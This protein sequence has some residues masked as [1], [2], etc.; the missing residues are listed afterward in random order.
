MALY[1]WF[2]KTGVQP[3]GDGTV[4]VLEKQPGSYLTDAG[5]EFNF[6][7]CSSVTWIR[8][9]DCAW[10]G[11][12]VKPDRVMTVAGPGQFPWGVGCA[13]GEICAA[14]GHMPCDDGFEQAWSCGS[15]PASQVDPSW[16]NTGTTTPNASDPVIQQLLE[17]QMPD[18]PE[19]VAKELG[20]LGTPAEGGPTIITG[21]TTQPGGTS[22]KTVHPDGSSS[23][24]TTNYNITYNNNNVSVTETN[25]TQ[26]YDAN[27]APSGSPIVDTHA[28][29]QSP[30]S[31]PTPAESRDL[32]ADHPEILACQQMGSYS[33]PSESLGSNNINVSV[34]PVSV[35]GDATCPPDM[36]ASFLG[37][38]IT[39]SWELPC[40]FANGI[41]NLVI[42]AAWLLAAFIVVSSPGLR[43]SD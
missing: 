11:G 35:A 25:T 15:K 5:A 40:Q 37:V 3:Q 23:Q 24:T 19:G 33:A 27:N 10:H 32:C 14:W 13:A 39:V 9:Q 30:A 16:I 42:A 4:S 21:P 12:G 43:G 31:Q 36:S 26:R 7:G 6:P 8:S 1:D 22:P 2:S 20:Q 34:S 17:N 38:P 18:N 29:T 41:R 28:P